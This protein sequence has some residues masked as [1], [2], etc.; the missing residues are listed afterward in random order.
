[1]KTIKF[2]DYLVPLVLSGEKDCTWRLFDDK[3]IQVGDNVLL[4]NW[5]TKEQFGSAL[6]VSVKE[7]MLK[8]LQDS[9]FEGHEKFESTE[10]MYESY[11]T[12][13]GDNVVPESVVKIIKF[14]LQS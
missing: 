13:Y 1:M 11:R 10:K 9:D 6:I 7:K 8:E 5:N 12:Y 4:I 3:D 2:R 14:K